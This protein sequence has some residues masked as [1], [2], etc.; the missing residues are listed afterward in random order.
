MMLYLISNPAKDKV[1]YLKTGLY[2]IFV[3]LR[4]SE[5]ENTGLIL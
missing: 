1:K 4:F 3:R 5:K 2:L